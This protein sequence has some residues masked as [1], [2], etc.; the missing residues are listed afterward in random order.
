MNDASHNPQAIVIEDDD[1]LAVIFSQAIKLAG[2]DTQRIGDGK[3]A[4]QALKT[5]QPALIVLD[6]HLPNVSG[7]QVLHAIRKDDKLQKIQ[8]ILVTADP[9]LS[10]ALQD[11]ADFVFIKPVTFS[12]LRDLAARLRKTIIESKLQG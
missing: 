9:A 10:D 12:Q 3:A 8:V 11:E 6:L 5:T 7:V 4:L 1:K 2:F